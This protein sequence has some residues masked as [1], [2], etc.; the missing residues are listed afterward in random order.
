MPTICIARLLSR[1]DAIQNVGNVDLMGIVCEMY[2][3]AS[4]TD[5]INDK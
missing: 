2:L 4:I 3:I 5:I 1:K